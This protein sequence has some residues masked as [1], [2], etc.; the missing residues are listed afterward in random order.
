MKENTQP[1]WAE[2][3]EDETQETDFAL[4]LKYAFP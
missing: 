3:W 4:Q 1:L 2:E